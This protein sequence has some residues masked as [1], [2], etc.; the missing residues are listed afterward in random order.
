MK[1]KFAF[2]IVLFLYIPIIS[3]SSEK[4]I[5]ATIKPLHS[6]VMNVVDNEEV[7]LL[8]DGNIS[9]HD[10]HLKPSDMK[11]IKNADHFF[12]DKLN[13]VSEEIKKYIKNILD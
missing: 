5:V 11:K 3:H 8:L 10:Y 13:L 7:F 6:I 9:P 4:K 2:L 1:L 12:T